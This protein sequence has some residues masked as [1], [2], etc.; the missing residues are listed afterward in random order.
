[1]SQEIKIHIKNYKLLKEG[2]WDLS[3]GTIF[4]AQ[5]GNKKGKT[6]FLNL[7]QAL[8]EVK[9]T[10][11]NPVTFGEKEGFA[12]GTIPGADG[13]QY[14]FRYDFNIDGKN[15]FQFIAPDNK[16]V[17]GI[18]EM[19]AIFN[20][21]HFTLEEFFEWSKTE[22][23]RAKQRAIFMNL[24]SEK[25]RE[26]IMKIDA[27]VHPTKGTMIDSR[28]ELNKSVDFLKKSIDN[29]V[30]N[31]E[32]QKLIA[33]APAMQ[34]LFETLSTRKEEIDETIK[35]FDTYQVKLDAENAKLDPL[36]KSHDKQVESLTN[37]IRFAKEEIERLT[38]ELKA[39]EKKLE[40]EN[41]E[42]ETSEKAITAAITEL[43]T[44]F[45]VKVLEASKL[46]L[47]GDGT[48]KNIGLI[49]RLEV[50]KTLI[51]Q[52]NQLDVLVKQK[53]KNEEDHKKKEDEVSK[54]DEKITTLRAK[55]KEIIKNSPNMPVGWSIDDDYVTIDNIPFLET[56]ICKSEATAAIAQLMMRVNKAP[57]MLMGDAE[58][59]GYEVLN[60]LEET[61]KSLGKV[62][63]F[64]E[65]VRSADEMR[66]VGYDEIDHEVKKEDKELF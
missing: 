32:Q 27:E 41:A 43:N 46:E 64:A 36:K 20:Y 5:G 59:L 35:G 50:G 22:P 13:L 8:M 39:D 33:E 47:N 55:K 3:N 56:D 63:L 24:L 16:V 28:K 12:T 49:K 9:D 26:E 40:T 34:K 54:L 11:V 48:E 19:R 51:N 31:A 10:T 14:Q 6:S 29:V 62:M 30:F 42:Y 1:M 53:A 4:F 58:A 2:E 23:G 66:L 61:A 15:K 57:L 38:K 7:I 17:K 45:D 52:Y 18:T 37:S 60:K 21:T 25:E 44:K 65:H